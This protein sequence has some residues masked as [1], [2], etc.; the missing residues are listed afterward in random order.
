M[1]HEYK[2]YRL[3]PLMTPLFNGWTIPLKALLKK[4]TVLAFFSSQG[5]KFHGSIT[6]FEKKFLLIS[7]RAGW[8][9]GSRDPLRSWSF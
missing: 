9:S 5:T 4:L 1:V 7:R 6:L 3:I 8:V 2:A